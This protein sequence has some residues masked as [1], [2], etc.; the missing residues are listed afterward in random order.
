MSITSPFISALVSAAVSFSSVY[1]DINVSD[2][3]DKLYNYAQRNTEQSSSIAQGSNMQAGI[4][5]I[6][7]ANDNNI[8]TNDNPA[9]T[10]YQLHTLAKLPIIMYAVRVDDEI[11]KGENPD[12]ISMI[13]GFSAEA[14]NKMWEKYGGV[15]IIQDLA[16]RYNLQETTAKADWH[17]STMSAVDVGRLIRRFMDDEDISDSK[18]KWTLDLLKTAPMDVS[19]EDLSW[20]IPSVTG[21]DQ[22][23][24]EGA[25]WAQG[26][27]PSGNKPM[28]RH[29][30]G[31]IGEGYQFIVVMMGQVP[32]HTSN[33]DANRI[34]TQT[35]QELIAGG[36][37]SGSGGGI[38]LGEDNKNKNQKFMEKNEKFT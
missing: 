28:V 11:A 24:A 37:E 7:R 15:S 30:V 16:E 9:H 1:A 36:S 26:W 22:G 31:M 27:S 21:A 4:V 6:D 23:S 13:Q 32:E 38:T 17:D 29:S 34:A 20:G 5:T 8:T 3:P 10:Q 2:P 33:G 12:A 19:G 25:V 18:K 35:M 14:T